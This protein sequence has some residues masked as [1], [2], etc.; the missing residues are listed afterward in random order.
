MAEFQTK[1]TASKKTNPSNDVTGKHGQLMSVEAWRFYKFQGF[2]E[3]NPTSGW[4]L[5]QPGKTS[6]LFFH[7]VGLTNYH[8][9]ILIIP[10]YQSA[11]PPVPEK[12]KS[13]GI[14]LPTKKTNG[15]PSHHL[16]GSSRRIQS[17]P[18][19]FR[20]LGCDAT[21]MQRWV[22][23]TLHV[24]III[25]RPTKRGEKEG[26]NNGTGKKLRICFLVYPPW[27]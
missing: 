16:V 11:P 27:N 10:F 6:N 14:F 22:C 21:L 15:W 4:K 20:C 19:M 24:I 25:S 1:K 9:Y 3:K 7:F 18:L 26:W 2:G 17:E 5:H 8:Y 12:K 23:Y 13:P